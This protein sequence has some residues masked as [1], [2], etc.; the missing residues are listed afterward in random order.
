MNEA[1]LTKDLA[2]KALQDFFRITPFVLFAT[3]ASCAVDNDFGMSGL[4]EFLEEEF[5]KKSS[6]LTKNQNSEWRSVF[7]SNRGCLRF[8]KGLSN[9]F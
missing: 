6:E 2:F 3:G 9:G 8:T 4:A 7:L 5:T 1:V